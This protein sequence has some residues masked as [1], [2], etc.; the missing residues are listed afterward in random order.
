M[1]V[2]VGVVGCGAIARR[3][4][5]PTLQAAGAEVTAFASRSRAS[6]EAAAVEAGGGSVFDDWRDLVAHDEVD[7]VVV[8]TPNSLH[9]PIAVAAL[10]AGRH[11]L[12]EKPIATTVADADR[13]LTAADDAGRVLM[14]AHDARATAGVQALRRLVADGALGTI[15][16]VTA[17]LSHAGP[18]AWT[19]SA[20]FRDDALSGGGALLDLGGHLVDALRHVL[21]DEIV[22]VTALRAPTPVDEDAAVAFRTATGTLGTV[23]VGW[24]AGAGNHHAVTLEGTDGSAHLDSALGTVLRRRG[25]D[26]AAMPVGDPADHPTTVFVRAVAGEATPTPDGHDGRAALAVVLAA[27]ESAATGQHVTVARS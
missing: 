16:A 9:A 22:E 1:T 24:R 6:A 11:V 21:A 10:Q 25:H 13:M 23:Q 8:C 14:V 2:R 26:P 19:D 4:H 27:H 18:Q 3:S 15:T 7:A 12:V 17:R 20:W 5:V